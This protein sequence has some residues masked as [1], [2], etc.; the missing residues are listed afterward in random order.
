MIRLVFFLFLTLSF[1][2]NIFADEFSEG[3]KS[4]SSRL[5]ESLPNFV[6]IDVTTETT[7]VALRDRDSISTEPHAADSGFS[8]FTKYF[9]SISFSRMLLKN[10]ISDDKIFFTFNPIVNFA[11]NRINFEQNYAFLRTS[12]FNLFRVSVGYGRPLNWASGAGL[13]YAQ[14]AP[15]IIFSS[16][17]WSSPVNGGQEDRTFWNMS[18]TVG[19]YR[20]IKKHFALRIFAK[21]IREDAQL[22]DIA[23]DRSQGF[24]VP[25]ESVDER[26]IGFSLCY[27]LPSIF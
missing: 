6:G 15:G 20:Q 16:V 14:I 13:F 25:V 24:D 17:S 7:S 18:G 10:E 26:I 11:Y 23:L 8:E 22:W 1:V 19:F 12:D 2:Q 5:R 9:G 3:G 21:Y 4:G 27:L